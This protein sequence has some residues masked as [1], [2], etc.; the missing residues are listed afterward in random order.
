MLAARGVRLGILYR[1]PV[2]RVA[3][4]QAAIRG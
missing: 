1:A 2:A 3:A 4:A